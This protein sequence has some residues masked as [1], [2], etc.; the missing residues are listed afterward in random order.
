VRSR[1]DAWLRVLAALAGTLP[2]ALLASACLAR[3]LPLSE[4]TRFA[5][6]FTAVIPLWVTAMCF[7]FLARSGTRAWGACIGSSLLFAALVYGVP[8]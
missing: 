5:I 1:A 3:F 2:V 7:T 8:Q 4:D 6:G